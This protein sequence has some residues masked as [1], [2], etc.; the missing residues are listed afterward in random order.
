MC[1]RYD[2]SGICGGAGAGGCRRKLALTRNTAGNSF[3]RVAYEN[4]KRAAS[5]FLVTA[6]LFF[7]VPAFAANP[8]IDVPAGHWSYE[9]I[10]TLASRGVALG[11]QDGSYKGAQPATRYEIA[12]IVGRALA[13]VD[14]RRADK[15]EAE[16]L[17]RLVLEYSEELA[18]L[19]VK[20]DALDRRFAVLEDGAGGWNI[21]GIFR[22][23]VMFA[24]SDNGESLYTQ[25][26]ADREFNKERF[27]LFLT[28]TI[29]QN[30][31]FYAQYRTGGSESG[32]LGDAEGA[33]WTQIY[34]D[35]RLPWDMD[36]RIGRF[37]IDFEDDYGFYVDDDALFGD[38]AAD[39]FRLRKS[40]DAITATAI[41]GRN[42]ALDDIW[43]DIYGETAVFMTYVL[44][45]HWTPTE[46]F[47]AGAT[48]YWGK[49]DSSAYDVDIDIDTYGLYAGGDLTDT[50][51]LR[52]IYYFQKLGGD[53]ASAERDDTPSAWKAII[54][55]QQEA[56]KFTS[57]WV[58]YSQ[59]DNSFVTS[60]W[61]RYGIGGVNQ[62]SVLLNQP[63]NRQ[64][65]SIWFARAVQQWTEQWSTILRFAHADFDTPGLSDAKEW[66]VGIGYQY[67][68]VIYF[69]LM[70][71]CV[72]FGTHSAAYLASPGGDTYSGKEN[73]IR[74]STS[75]SF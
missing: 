41:I 52:G 28:K 66:G 5:L 47:Y 33:V 13:S 37:D 73:V 27:R 67:T 42:T 43:E 36:L 63:V 25:S 2:L 68:P 46:W 58:E 7:S 26:G 48:G 72:D 56:L 18:A 65:A 49:E 69:E 60:A 44:D 34:L 14:K 12:S 8:F 3:V 45:L 38:F 20:A 15:Q 10:E 21:R 50:I 4:M 62:A 53:I 35:T 29:D 31:F 64:T 40:W 17:Q 39:G 59:V 1:C 32:G 22:F 70:Y 71:D 6:L 30:T 57:L 61:P 16:L 23:D 9:A 24:D 11:Y 74:L 55:V 51:A 75:V 54:D 19:G